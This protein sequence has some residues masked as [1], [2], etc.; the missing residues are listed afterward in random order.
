[1]F[2]EIITPNIKYYEKKNKKYKI[3]P[4]DYFLGQRPVSWNTG[5]RFHSIRPRLG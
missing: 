2:L 5:R 3:P 4:K 1:M